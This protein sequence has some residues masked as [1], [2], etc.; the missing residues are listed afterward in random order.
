MAGDTSFDEFAALDEWAAELRKLRREWR[1][2][3]ANSDER[4]LLRAAIRMQTLYLRLA[5]TAAVRHSQGTKRQRHSP[6]AQAR[7]GRP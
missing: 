3:P 6:K 2:K 5:R 4:L 7:R 1:Q